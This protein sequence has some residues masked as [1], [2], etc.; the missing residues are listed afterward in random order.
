MRPDHLLGTVVYAA[1][2]IGAAGV[3]WLLVELLGG[4]V[5]ATFPAAAARLFC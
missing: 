4:A 1:L 2:A 3:A 5:A